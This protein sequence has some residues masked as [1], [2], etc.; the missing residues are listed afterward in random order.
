MTETLIGIVVILAS[1][2]VGRELLIEEQPS[3][4]T[5]LYHLEAYQDIIGLLSLLSGLLGLYHSLA[6]GLAN[7]YTPIYWG[8]WTS[9]N[10]IAIHV[11]VSLCFPLL[12]QRLEQGVPTLAF[13]CKLL[14]NKVSQNPSW[15]CWFGILLGT[16]RVLFPWLAG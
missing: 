5:T 11:G 15:W 14:T 7:I 13:L 16:W 3:L 8:L 12:E 10:F 2:L 1:G 9:S 6:T 4:K